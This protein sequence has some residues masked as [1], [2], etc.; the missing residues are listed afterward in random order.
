MCR[1][2]IKVTDGDGFVETLVVGGL[3]AMLEATRKAGRPLMWQFALGPSTIS[4]DEQIWIDYLTLQAIADAMP[5]L[6][7]AI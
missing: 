4:G 6:P 7:G 3:D 1:E 2:S 5:D